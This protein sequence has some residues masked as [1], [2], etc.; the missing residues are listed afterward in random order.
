MCGRESGGGEFYIVLF[1]V[2]KNSIYKL[3]AVKII[4]RSSTTDYLISLCMLTNALFLFPSL[5]QMPIVRTQ[6]ALSFVSV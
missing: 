4:D 3:Q 1:Q 6:K 5:T 2:L